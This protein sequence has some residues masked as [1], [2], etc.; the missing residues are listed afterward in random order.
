MSTVTISDNLTGAHVGT[1]TGVDDAQLKQTDATGNYGASET[2]EA[3]KYGGADF[4]HSVIKFTG[5]SNII[6]PVTVTS[7]TFGFYLQTDG[8]AGAAHTIDIRRALQNWIEA[9]A[10]WSVYSTGNNWNTVGGIG[11]EVDRISAV[12]GQVT[13]I[14]TAGVFYSVTKTSGGLVDDVQGWINGSFANYGWHLERNGA[15]ADATFKTY[16][17]SDNAST[18]LRPFLDVTYTLGGGGADVVV[19]KRMQ[20]L[21]YYPGG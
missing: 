17:S 2:F 4:T 3:S 7:I 21:I 16:A 15:G 11:A 13:N 6:G 12:S 18:D 20:G 9:E 5:L 14:T 10:T 8:A 19:G 1:Y